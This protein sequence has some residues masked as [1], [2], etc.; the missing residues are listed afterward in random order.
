MTAPPAAA[1]SLGADAADR[2]VAAN[3][4]AYNYDANDNLLSD[5]QVTYS[6]DSANRLVGYTYNGDVVLVAAAVDGLRTDY[7]QDVTAPAKSEPV[8]RATCAFLQ[9]GRNLCNRAVWTILLLI[10]V[11][12]LNCRVQGNPRAGVG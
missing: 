10:V 12:R 3:G 11:P 1:R 7:V 6:Y 2:L 8:A 5:G 9:S 4:Q